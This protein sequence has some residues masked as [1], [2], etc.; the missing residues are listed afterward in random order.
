[1]IPPGL[2]PFGFWMSNDSR[3]WI[4]L[5]AESVFPRTGGDLTEAW[6]GGV[7]AA[8][9]GR[10]EAR[11]ASMEAE[12]IGLGVGIMGESWKVT[13]C[14][15]APG[16]GLPASVVVKFASQMPE[17]R[18]HGVNLGLYDAEIRFYRDLSA[19][20]STRHPRCF[21]AEKDPDSP[22]F[23]LVMEDLSGMLMVDQYRG[24]D[25]EQAEAAVLA[26]ADLH[27]SWWERVREEL[28][29]AP[30]VV[31]E[32]IEAMGGHWP[33]L[34]PVFAE[35][36]ADSLPEGGK[37]VGETAARL[38]WPLMQKLGESP[39]TLLHMDYRCENLFFDPAAGAGRS[40][41]V[42]IDWQTIGRGAGAYDLS[43]LIGGSL[44]V[45]DRRRLEE[46]LVDTYLRRLAAGGV[47][48]PADSFWQDY[49]LGHLVTG[50]S[51]CVL[52][53]A[54]MDLGNARGRQLIE[55]MTERHFCAAADLDSATLAA[56]LIG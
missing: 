24:L 47:D 22:D 56:E 33:V 49:R 37:E 13:L 36:F 6:L 42:V 9:A 10:P 39:W 4:G 48:Y 16:P 5:S 25:A 51:V 12:Q 38:Y 30:S 20:T 11:L 2:L 53:G 52:T 8:S 31:H 29:W 27:S 35:R 7:I 40:G 21:H 41:V 28:P 45:E 34:W 15:D 44:T 17:N 18:V 54:T 14:W 1:M 46:G 23:V 3:G 55:I 26:L 50:T 19:T 43:Y 32:R